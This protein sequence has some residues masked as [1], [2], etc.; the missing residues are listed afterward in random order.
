MPYLLQK[1]L[2]MNNSMNINFS[3]KC[4]TKKFREKSMTRVIEK[5]KKL[6]KSIK[7]TYPDIAETHDYKKLVYDDPNHLTLM[8]SFM[9]I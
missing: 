7:E 6:I 9:Q 3:H 4:A 8:N 1:I 2:E 5:N